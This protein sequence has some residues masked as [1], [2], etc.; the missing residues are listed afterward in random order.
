MAVTSSQS[1]SAVRARVGYF[2]DLIALPLI[3]GIETNLRGANPRRKSMEEV[4]DELDSSELEVGLYPTMEMILNPKLAMFPSAAISVLGP[5]NLFILVSK[6]FPGEIQRVLVDAEDYG[7]ASFAQLMMVQKLRVRP[8]L[9]RSEVSLNPADFD[10]KAD[11]HDAYVLTGLNALFVRKAAFAF[12]MD[13]T[14]AWYDLTGLPFMILSWAVR[15]SLNIGTLDRD[16]GDLAKR[17][18]AEVA[19]ICKR[20]ADRLKIPA[21][22]LEAFL[23]RTLR[24]TVGPQEV[25]GVRRYIKEITSG[26]LVEGQ[27]T[28]NVYQSASA[29]QRSTR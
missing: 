25:T 17:N 2:E 8:E 18:A 3:S 27:P 20:E 13:L 29:P 15:K 26:N 14:Q 23:S 22:S 10:F 7:C 4:R 19:T 6:G 28:L 1:S 12:S 9:Y 11:P 16:L 21:A 5:S 24:T